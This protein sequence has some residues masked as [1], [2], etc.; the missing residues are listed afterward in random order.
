MS[1]KKQHQPHV[2]QD[3][4]EELKRKNRRRLVGASA[5]VVVAG[6]LLAFAMNGGEE[7]DA[8]QT[9]ASMVSEPLPAPEVTQ[10]TPAGSDAVAVS[11]PVAGADAEVVQTASAPAVQD[12][13][14]PQNTSQA[15]NGSA[16][17]T[18]QDG[19]PAGTG[20]RDE[21]VVLVNDTLS[22]SDIQ[23][24]NASGSSAPPPVR[25]DQTREQASSVQDDAAAVA[26]TA[27]AQQRRQE[28]RR[29]QAEQ[30]RQQAE[31]DAAAKRAQDVRAEQAAKRRAELAR[32]RAAQQ[33]AAEQRAAAKT[34]SATPKAG[35]Y[36]KTDE[37]DALA[38]KAAEKS[39][40][41]AAKDSKRARDLLESNKAGAGR[42]ATIQAGYNNKAQAQQLQRK[43]QSAGIQAG[44]V[45]INTDKGKVY[46]V[47]SGAYPNKEAANRVLDRLRKE[48]GIGGTVNEE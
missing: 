9:S 29:R 35:D 17:E 47:K 13:S 4:Y 23:G 48:R 1:D 25:S 32:Q 11:E 46:R 34:A 39:R 19:S 42:R 12:A 31:R 26:A 40:E 44:I 18:V 36:R 10:L 8:V 2:F 7:G 20:S 27:A 22:D 16:T 14:R 41:L 28:A 45:E 33:R 3:E 21:P 43:M 38:Q 15:R 30:R 37:P 24:L 6:S 5:L